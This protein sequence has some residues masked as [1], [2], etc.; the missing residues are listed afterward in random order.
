[1]ENPGLLNHAKPQNY[2]SNKNIPAREP[3]QCGGS[4]KIMYY[5]VDDDSADDD[6]DDDGGDDDVRACAI[7]MHMDTSQ[8]PFCFKIYWENAGRESRDTRLCEPAQ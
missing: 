5:N 4:E 3:K 8:K 7:E 1:L 2:Q 6:D